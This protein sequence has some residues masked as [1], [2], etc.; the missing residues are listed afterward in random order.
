MV[1]EAK[2]IDFKKTDSVLEAVLLE[3][4]LIKKFQPRYN[5]K[6]KDDKSNNCV[7]I[8]K[9]S[10]PKIL[11]VRKKDLTELKASGQKF[12]DVFGPFPSAGILREALKIIRKIF[13]YRDEKC[14]SY[15]EQINKGKVPKPCFNRQIGLCP[16]VCTGEISKIDYAKTIRNI[17]LMFQGKKD[18]L[19]QKLEREMKVSAKKREFEKAGE[20]RNNIY[21]LK[22]IQDVSL[23]KVDDSPSVPAE[24]FR[25]ESYDIAHMG[26]GN[27]VGVMVVLENRLAKKDD[28]RK[29]RIRQK[30]GGDD[31]A[32]LREVITRRLGHP[33]WPTADLVVID[34]GPTQLRAAESLFPENTKIVSVVKDATHKPDHILGNPE[35][36]NKYKKEILL[37][38]SESHRFAI[39]YHRKRRG[40]TFKKV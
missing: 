38:N 26:G 17:E 40:S 29:F 35:I 10:Y 24:T 14:V 11:I 37:S 7:V 5:T 25:I 20:A 12:K 23:V 4:D 2:S 9:E 15:E 39:A 6:E 18:R 8:T 32:A 27:T 33:E 30:T 28:Y 1:G 13:P 19:I 22:H 21:A 31:L 34:G 3:A 36:I 16:G